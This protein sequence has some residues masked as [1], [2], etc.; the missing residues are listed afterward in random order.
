MPQVTN[1]WY[2][3]RTRA[4][5][6][7]VKSAEILI[8]GDIGESWYGDSI[9]AKDF[10]QEIAAIDAE[11]I[12]VRINSY[13]GSVSDG[14]AI[15]NAIK[16][17][18]AT[19]TT[20]IEGVGASIASLIAM[21]GDTVEMAENA[22]LMIHAPWGYAAGNSADLREFADMLD[23]WAQAMATS[24]A[25][26]T[27]RTTEEMLA[28]LTDGQD[29]WYTAEQ[30]L[31]ETF[32]D[33]VVQAMPMAASFDRAALSARFKSLPAAGGSPF[34]A[35]AAPTSKEIDMPGTNQPAAPAQTAAKSEEEIKAAAVKAEAQRREEIK[36]SFAKFSG[37]E[38]VAAL[39]ASCEGDITCSVQDANNK[40][41][42]HLGKGSAPVAG[43]YAVTVEDSRD[44]FRAGAMAALMARANLAKDDRVN[45]Y[46][47]LSLMDMARECL[48]MAHI[49]VRGKSKMDV[50]AAA[51]TSTGDFPLLLSS[52]AEK[53]MLKGYEEADET[54]QKWTNV[55]QLGDFKAGKRLDLNTFPSLDKVA[56]GAEYK[57]ASVGERGE[58]VQLATYGKLFAITRQA[59]INDDLDAFSKIPA[60][61]GRAAIRT[62]G[63]LVYAILTGNPN[64]ADG[65][66]LFHA[67]HGN[68]LTGAALSTASTDAMRVAMARQKVGSEAAL[69]IRL[70]YIIAPVSL[71]GAARVVANSEYEVGILDATNKLS[72]RN[73]TT[74]NSM[75]GLFEVISDARLDAASTAA[76]Y[77]SANPGMYDTIEVSYLDGIQTPTLEQQGGWAV[78]GVEFKV[79]LDAG[80]K[81][82]DFRTLAKNP[83]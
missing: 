83:G 22:L 70:G 42:A 26:K 57:Y 58:T 77:G 63:D 56:E 3:I 67:D 64:M 24:Y 19:V 52:V 62:V 14:I 20:S 60:R 53:A 34:A 66:A 54:F 82:L 81:A 80:V 78:D 43:G 69:N 17:H 71:E 23:T 1:K 39:Q 21:A 10:V 31:A 13:G 11:Q 29:H 5:A 73:N 40:L 28:L 36:A 50:V 2:S 7:G 33:T 18:P 65:V 45:N 35:A 30:A 55:G 47:G 51:F 61:M 12:T 25:S 59:I 6:Q 72:N 16:R 37:V 74:P 79:R 46:R 41:L 76:W 8:F 75:R 38:G 68:L 9:L 15:H 4:A 32:V 48:A 44:K 27:G 49:D